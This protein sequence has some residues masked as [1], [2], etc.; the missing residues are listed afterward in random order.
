M[1]PLSVSLLVGIYLLTSYT[2]SPSH[3]WNCPFW[4]MLI[5]VDLTGLNKFAC[6]YLT[7]LVWFYICYELFIDGCVTVPFCILLSLF[8][9]G[10]LHIPVL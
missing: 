4:I 1:C 3:D 6:I 5:H 2:V 9:K 8:N 7:E 10:S